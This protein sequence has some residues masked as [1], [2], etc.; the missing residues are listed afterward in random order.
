[1][2]LQKFRDAG[3]S[4]EYMVW[5]ETLTLGP[6]F[7]QIDS[8]LFWEMRSQFMEVA[9]GARLAEY[10]RKVI[11]EFA[12][13]RKF[14]G[15]EI[16]LWYEYDVFCQVNFIAL[17]SYILRNKKDIRI[18]IICVGD[19]ASHNRRVGLGEI[20]TKEYQ[21]LYKSRKALVKYDLLVAD[22]AWMLFC[23]MGTNQFQSIKND[24]LPY[25]SDALEASKVL[26]KCGKSQSPLEEYISAVMV[27]S[28]LKGKDLLRK[29]LEEDT[30]LGF[31]DLQFDYIVK[32][33]QKNL[34]VS[35]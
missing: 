19:H 5:R 2:T 21:E 31:G 3:F 25:L 28:T 33:L 24:Q 13:L 9:Y 12:K 16:V 20:E 32:N 30:T 22:K 1:M 18:S 10:R 7:Y 35:D 15:D 23:G 29:L 17:M 27:S 4:G 8:E 14:S 34:D 26:F 6:L 11:M